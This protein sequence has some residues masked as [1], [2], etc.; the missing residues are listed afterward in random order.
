[1]P[2]KLVQAQP[3]IFPSPT[4]GAPNSSYPILFLAFSPQQVIT[5]DLHTTTRT[6]KQQKIKQFF[7]KLPRISSIPLAPIVPAR[8][9]TFKANPRLNVHKHLLSY[10][11]RPPTRNPVSSYFTS[12]SPM[13][14]LQDSW[15]H[16]LPVVDTSLT[17]KVF[18]QNPNGLT[19][20]HQNL[21]LQHNFKVCQSYSALFSASL[22]QM[23]TGT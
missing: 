22:K 10:C 5:Q 18:L 15:G 17:F 13:H 6:S 19:L 7:R 3:K 21:P 1:M 23:L 4:I 20:Y 12:K 9:P 14:E 16:T 11:H 2:L 8:A